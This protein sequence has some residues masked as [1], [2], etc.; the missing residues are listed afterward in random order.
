MKN[1]IIFCLTLCSM[2]FFS[3]CEWCQCLNKKNSPT[4]NIENPKS[5]DQLKKVSETEKPLKP[6]SKKITDN[7]AL[8]DSENHKIEP[9][10]EE[11]AQH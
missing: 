8:N 6:S 2:L 11:T 10:P 1:V 3:G 9:I 5:T 7:A 4:V